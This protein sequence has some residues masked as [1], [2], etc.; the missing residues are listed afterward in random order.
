LSPSAPRR[1]NDV[2][3]RSIDSSFDAAVAVT[4]ALTVGVEVVRMDGLSHLEGA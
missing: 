2:N 4:S 1:R 3:Q